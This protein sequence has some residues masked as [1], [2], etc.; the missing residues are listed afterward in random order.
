VFKKYPCRAKLRPAKLNPRGRL[1]F[2]SESIY[3]VKEIQAEASL[4]SSSAAALAGHPIKD[5]A[6]WH[7]SGLLRQLIIAAATLK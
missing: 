4:S 2:I 7:L 6:G 3:A 1:Y 5:T